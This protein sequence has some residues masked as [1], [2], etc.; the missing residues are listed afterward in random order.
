MEKRNQQ[1]MLI[2]SYSFVNK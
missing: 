1:M 2:H